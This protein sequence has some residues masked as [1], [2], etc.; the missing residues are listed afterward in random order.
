MLREATAAAPQLFDI[1]GPSCVTE[2][3]CAEA[4]PCGNPYKDM[5]QLLS[6]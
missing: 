6:E 5:E 1:A 3:K 2:G 4:H